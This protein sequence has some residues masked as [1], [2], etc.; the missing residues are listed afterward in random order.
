MSTLP[1]GSAPKPS[2]HDNDMDFGY[3]LMQEM[4]GPDAARKFVDG[5]FG[6]GPEAQAKPAVTSQQKPTA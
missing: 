6:D 1:E 2:Q 4:G 5:A 3:H